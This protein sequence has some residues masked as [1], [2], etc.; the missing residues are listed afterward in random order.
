MQ[1]YIKHVFIVGIYHGYEKPKDSI[2]YLKD[3]IEEILDLTQNRVVINNV[4]KKITIN[5]IRCD[6]PAKSFIM[7]I[8]THSGYFSCPRCT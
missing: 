8:K 7:R 1:P 5:V 2:I 6:S 4:K 3:L